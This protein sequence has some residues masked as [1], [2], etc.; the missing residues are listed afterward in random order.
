MESDISNKK[1]F[2][3]CYMYPYQ[4]IVLKGEKISF[5]LDEI[6]NCTYN[7]GQLCRVV[8]Y[9]LNIFQNTKVRYA[10]CGDGALVIESDLELFTANDLILHFNDILCKLYIGGIYVEAINNKDITT[11]QFYGE[12]MIWPVNFGKS[13][14]SNMHARIRMHLANN[15]E[16]IFLDSA[17]KNSKTIGELEDALSK[18]NKVFESMQ[19][20]S[21]FY[22][23]TGITELRYGN[24]SSALSNLWI[25]VEQITNYLW[26][27]KFLNDK[28]R[29]PNI[30]SRLQA[31]KKDNR[32]YSISVKQEILFQLGIISEDIYS[33]L[34][35]IRKAR[36]SLVHDGCMVGK[37]VAINLYT[38][39]KTLL[40]FPSG[41]NVNLLLDDDIFIT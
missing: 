27:N 15:M 24:W 9:L 1:K 5:S 14:N 16:T 35:L 41:E 7:H 23:L 10:V 39:I 33:D 4:L 31:L 6:N 19:N 18:G 17:C 13:L 30:P 34:F 25:V 29:N 26:E 12:N 32:T 37:K 3:L 22:L 21:T 28:V 40:P 2:W 38:V 36:N 20:I 8:G 11:G